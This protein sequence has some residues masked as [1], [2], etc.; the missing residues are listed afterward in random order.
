MRHSL[1]A[2][3]AA[4]RD[5]VGTKRTT[6]EVVRL[7]PEMQA[8]IRGAVLGWSTLHPDGPLRSRRGRRLAAALLVS[9]GV[10]CWAL[11]KGRFDSGTGRVV[12]AAVDALTTAASVAVY[13]DSGNDDGM[14]AALLPTVGSALEAT[15]TR[16]PLAGARAFAVP[17]AVAA[18]VRRATGRPTSAA[19]LLTWPLLACG[20][21]LALRLY[22]Q[23]ARDR[24]VRAER[25]RRLAGEQGAAF[26]GRR[27]HDAAGGTNALDLIIHTFGQLDED[28]DARLEEA[29]ELRKEMDDI[30]GASAEEPSAALLAVALRQYEVARRDP[31]AAHGVFLA[32]GVA[33]HDP[34]DEAGRLLLD[35]GQVERLTAELDARNATGRLSVFVRER[36]ERPHG[37]DLALTV[38]RRTPRGE[39]HVLDIPL[40]LTRATWRLELVTFGL[41]I[42]TMWQLAVCSPAHALVPVR[43]MAPAALINLAGAVL[44]EYVQRRRP[45]QNTADLALL[46]LPGCLYTAVVGPRTM[47]RPTYTAGGTPFHP[48]LH[49]LCGATYLWG[50]QFPEMSPRGRAG[51]VG[52]AAAVIAAAWFAGRRRPGDAQGFLAELLWSGLAGVGSMRLGKTMRDMGTRVTEEQKH[53]ALEAAREALL[54]GWNQQRRTAW[55]LHGHVDRLL[56]DARS[57]ADA[58]QVNATAKLKSLS[59]SQRRAADRLRRADAE[60][61]LPGKPKPSEGDPCAI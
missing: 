26:V 25:L 48:G 27:R 14:A 34:D 11:A 1:N 37:W 47:R 45:V 42:E 2:A 9:D 29:K 41:V 35:E 33:A 19:D 51:V 60:Q 36:Q 16:G 55:M 24:H 59:V 17:T 46:L 5:A 28:D 40:P 22:E 32:D 7:M 57:K 15:Y 3:V 10:Y 43:A 56:A 50:E 58:S 6:P 12:R 23:I 61:P 39:E 13:P 31:Y 20:V 52:G 53:L 21:G 38:H 30:R 49:A 54:T 4:M 18:G 8:L 44:A